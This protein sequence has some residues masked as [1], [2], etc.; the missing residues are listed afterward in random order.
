MMLLAV[1]SNIQRFRRDQIETAIVTPATSPSA[2]A[3]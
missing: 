1:Y 3:H 2:P